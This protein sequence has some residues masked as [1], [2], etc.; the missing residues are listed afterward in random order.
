MPTGT[1]DLVTT[2]LYSVHVLADGTRDRQH[3]LEIGRAVFVGRRADGDELQLA[4]GH[5]LRRPRW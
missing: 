5:A 2:T 4:V 1:V 3:V